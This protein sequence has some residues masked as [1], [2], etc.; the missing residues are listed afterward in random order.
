LKSSKIGFSQEQNIVKENKEYSLFNKEIFN[1]LSCPCVLGYQKHEEIKKT[2]L[3]KKA[4][5]FKELK[6]GFGRQGTRFNDKAEMDGCDP[7]PKCASSIGNSWFIHKFT[8]SRP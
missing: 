7:I 6:Q 2:D 5:L 8:K 4:P 1:C 3:K